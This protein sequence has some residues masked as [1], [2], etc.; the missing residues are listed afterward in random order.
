MAEDRSR[1]CG[2]TIS[3][4]KAGSE[5]RTIQLVAAAYIR[6]SSRV[7]PV[8]CRCAMCGVNEALIGSITNTANVTRRV[9]TL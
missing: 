6:A 5:S 2:K 1:S 8:W 3:A 9:A 4:T 7:S